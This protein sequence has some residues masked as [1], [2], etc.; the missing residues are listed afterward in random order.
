[1]NPTMDARRIYKPEQVGDVLGV[2]R[3]TVYRLMSDGSLESIKVGASRRITAEQL[4]AFLAAVGA[5]APR[6]TL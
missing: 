3:S 2:S 1:M 6:A 4:D 5:P